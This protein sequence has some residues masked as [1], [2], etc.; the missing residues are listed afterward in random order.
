MK[1]S[2]FKKIIP[3]NNYFIL[4]FFVFPNVDTSRYRDFL[5]YNF[6]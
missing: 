2:L 6:D 4:V 5:M 1:E 3:E